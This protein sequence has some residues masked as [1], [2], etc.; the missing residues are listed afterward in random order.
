MSVEPSPISERE[1]EIL[2]LVAMGATNQQIAHQLNISINTV[3]VNLRNIF[4]KIGAA[5]RTEATVYAIQQGLVTLDR[6]PDMATATIAPSDVVAEPAAPPMPVEVAEDI[7]PVAVEAPAPLIV[8]DI[9]LEPTHERAKVAEPPALELAATGLRAAIL[10]IVLAVILLGGLAVVGYILLQSRP[11]GTVTPAALQSDR[12]KPRAAL[13]RPR[14]DFGVATYDGKV[15]VIG[16]LGASGPSASIERYDPTNNIWAPLGDKP[17]PASRVQA[18]IVRGQIY[19][20]GGEGPDG[21]PLTVFEAYDPRNQRWQQLA[22]LPE[23]RSRY[24]LASVEGRLYL[25]GGWDGSSYRAEVFIYDPAANTWSTGAPLRAPRRDAG[26]TALEGRIYVIGGENESGALRLNERYDPSGNQGAQWNNATPLEVAVAS[27]AVTNVAS[28]IWVFDPQTR[29]ALQ[30]NPAADAWKSIAIPDT[31]PVSSRAISFN[32][33]SVFLFG[34]GGDGGGA[35]NE[36]QAIYNLFLPNT[37]AN[38]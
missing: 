20:P 9:T 14:T 3:K 12:W 22:P 10:P 15:Y 37:G 30:Y 2:R 13:P 16:G 8:S 28:N 11:G 25:F 31:V 17:T 24:A 18:A 6:Q 23:P 34:P 33:T 35:V 26:A 38:S 19:V 5:S 21:K 32:N 29:T 36:Y 7:V 1:R 4:G 27:P